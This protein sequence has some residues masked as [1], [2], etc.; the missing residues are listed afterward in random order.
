[1]P[2]AVPAPGSWVEYRRQRGVVIGF[3]SSQVIVRVGGMDWFA[4]FL[5]VWSVGGIYN[6][7]VAELAG[8][9]RA[10]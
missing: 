2:A 8:Y 10:A 1:M 3:T 6:F 7:Q 4:D 9:G 5:E